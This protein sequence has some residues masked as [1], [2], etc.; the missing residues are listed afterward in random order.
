[1]KRFLA[2]TVAIAA[3]SAPGRTRGAVSVGGGGAANA[4]SAADLQGQVN[5]NV[6]DVVNRPQDLTLAKQAGA[7]GGRATPNPGWRGVEPVIGGPYRWAN[8]DQAILNIQN[9]GMEP[10]KTLNSTRPEY[11]TYPSQYQDNSYLL[12][13]LAPDTGMDLWA[14]YQAFVRAVVRRY[15]RTA[16][17]GNPDAMPG[18]TRP[19]KYWSYTPEV[20]TFW[21]PIQDP[22]QRASDYAQMFALTA[23]AI[24]AVDPDAVVFLPFNGSPYLAAFAEGFLSRPTIRYQSQGGALETLTPAQTASEYADA[25]TFARNLIQRVP[26]DAIDLH[27]YGDPESAP[28]QKA[29]VLAT[30]AGFRIP[31]KPVWSMEGGEPYGK[32]GEM[33]GLSSGPSSCGSG[34][35]DSNRL[36][37]QSGGVI[38]HVALAFASGYQSVT[39]NLS[40][41]YSSAGAYFGDLDLLNACYLPRP[42]YYTL[43]MAVQMLV[44][45]ATAT[46]VAGTPAT[47]RLIRFTFANKADIYVAWDPILAPGTTMPHNLGAFLPFTAARVSHAVTGSGQTTGAVTTESTTGIALGPLPVLVTTASVSPAD[48]LFN[49]AE[50]NYPSLFSPAGTLSKTSDPYYYRYYSATNSYLG[51]SSTDNHVYYLNAEG[52]HDAG[53]LSGWRTTAGCQ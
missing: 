35:E 32:F 24:H 42:A 49:W 48:C 8:Q 16:A 7:S 38:K 51:T 17:N 29:W 39:F 6:L 9:A 40:P 20:G 37:V 43:Q 45:F 50:I 23:D 18:L 21:V 4:A 31:V 34:T 10:F 53:P 1:M 25:I 3:V 14:R 19:V 46:E 28:G 11:N 41:E 2:L 22:V 15:Y 12:P 33:T 5:L 52:L 44:P 47:L 27:L 13:H 36:A 26:Y 30:A